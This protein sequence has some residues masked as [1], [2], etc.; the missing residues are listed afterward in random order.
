MKTSSYL[1]ILILA[2]VAW[3]VRGDANRLVSIQTNVTSVVRSPFS[4]APNR[5][6][7]RASGNNV[8]RSMQL[9]ASNRLASAA[10][11]ARAPSQSNIQRIQLSSNSARAG[12]GLHKVGFAGSLVGAQPVSITTPDNH[13]LSFRP[14]LLAYHDTASGQTVPLGEIQD[15]GG[16]VQWPD[17]VIFT[18]AP[19]AV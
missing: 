18:Q 14:T 12:F 9:T 19:S 3:N 10:A 16:G 7:R 13:S 15:C 1:I 6:T 8:L 5:T 17:S 2:S 11:S 4:S